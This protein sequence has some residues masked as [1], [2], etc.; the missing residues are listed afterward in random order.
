M[1]DAGSGFGQYSYYC[2]RRFKS[3]KIHAV[4][5]KQEQIDDCR[6]FFLKAGISNVN[7]SVEDLTQPLHTDEFDLILSVDVMEHIK[8]DELVFRNFSKALKEGGLLLVNTPSSFGGSDAH[9]PDDPGFI[10]EHARSGYEPEE[11]RRKLTG[12]GL[13]VEEIRFTYSAWGTVSWKL[14]I[15]VPMLLLNRSKFFALILPF[16]YLLTFPF[17]LLFMYLD[18]RADNKTGTGLLVTARKS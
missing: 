12:A 16:Y 13:A 7:F 15:K 9:G 5:V 3:I 11:I 4:D 14:G 6:D 10:E 1:F 18:Y 8:D 17:A 2:A